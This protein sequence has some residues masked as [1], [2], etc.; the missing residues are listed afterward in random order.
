MLRKY[1]R[2]IYGFVRNKFLDLRDGLDYLKAKASNRKIVYSLYARVN[3]FGDQFNKDL[4]RYFNREMIHVKSYKKSQAVFTGSILGNFPKD[5]SGY[6]LGAGFLL[7]RYKRQNNNWKVLLLRGP[8]SAQQCGHNDIV[9][10]DPGILASHIYK[11]EVKKRYE[12]GV[13][14]NGREKEIVFNTKFSDKVLVIDPHRNAKDVINDLKSCKFI[15]SSSLHGLIFADVFRI[16]NIHLYF[17]DKVLGGYHKFKDYYLG[18]D[19][20]HEVINYNDDM[21]EEE[22]ISYCKLR[23]SENYLEQKQQQVIEIYNRI[24]DEIDQ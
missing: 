18:M 20:E 10:A 24:L 7:D 15:A 5:Y 9:F 6:I 14:P 12:L 1:L 23:Y 3:N 19:T 21:S 11:D 8:L 16:P 17:T 13:V 22:I 4:L 2:T